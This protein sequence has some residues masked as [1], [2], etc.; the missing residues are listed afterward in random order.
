MNGDFGPSFFMCTLCGS[1]GLLGGFGLFYF[2]FPLFFSPFLDWTGLD[3]DELGWVGC[4][5]AG[6][7]GR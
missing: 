3:R 1:M 7:I 4:V 5:G 2:S 6:W